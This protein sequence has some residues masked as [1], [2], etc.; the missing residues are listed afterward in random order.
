MNDAP[1]SEVA[2]AFG[3]RLTGGMANRVV[4]TTTAIPRGEDA[5]IPVAPIEPRWWD[6]GQL[7]LRG[8]IPPTL[9]ALLQLAESD[10][11]GLRSLARTALWE[12]CREHFGD[13]AAAEQDGWAL[14]DGPTLLAAHL[15]LPPAVPSPAPAPLQDPHSSALVRRALAEASRDGRVAWSVVSHPDLIELSLVRASLSLPEAILQSPAVR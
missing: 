3:Q 11:I 10:W 12:A 13:D 8:E 6:E 4:V 15:R 9:F 5:I 1:G 7:Q 2:A 14:L